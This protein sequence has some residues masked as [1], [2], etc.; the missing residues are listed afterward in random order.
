MRASLEA[1][2][3][4]ATAAPNLIAKDY[5]RQGHK[6]TY[7]AHSLGSLHAMEAVKSLFSQ[8]NLLQ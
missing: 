2:C 3:A 6:P 7:R 1:L 8:N 4:A 5:P